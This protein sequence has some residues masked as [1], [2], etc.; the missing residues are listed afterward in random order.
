MSMLP[1]EIRILSSR[2][3]EY[4]R[5]KREASLGRRL[6][7]LLDLDKEEQRWDSLSDGLHAVGELMRT[8][9]AEGPFVLGARLSYTDFFIAGSL[10]CTRE[11]DEGIFQRT[12]KYPGHSHIY[13]A[14]LPYMEKKN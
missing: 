13:E 8:H 1:R 5:R 3:Q 10:Q 2:S 14:C 9:K 6:E 4:F 12:A 11:V 7:D